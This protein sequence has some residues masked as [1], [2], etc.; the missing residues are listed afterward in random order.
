MD[1][2]V[3]IFILIYLLT[4]LVS[5]IELVPLSVAALGGALLTAWFGIQYNVFTLM[6]SRMK[7]L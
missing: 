4:I 3:V 1:V 6:F 2:T 5:A 7:K